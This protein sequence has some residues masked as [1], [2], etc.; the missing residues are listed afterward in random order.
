MSEAISRADLAARAPLAAGLCR[1][2]GRRV[3]LAALALC[4]I[5]AAATAQDSR[6][7]RAG[8]AGDEINLGGHAWWGTTDCTPTEFGEVYLDKAPGHGTVCVR[9]ADVKITLSFSGAPKCLGRTIRGVRVNYLAESGYVGPDDL[10]YTVKFT[11][12][13][14]TVAATVNVRPS[15]KPALPK[16]PAQPKTVQP[17]GLVPPCSA[18]VS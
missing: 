15:T 6:V 3:G 18:L 9:I 16:D 4:L 12:L 1:G 8:R 11:A 2:L 7:R 5:G 13:S 10:S 17:L 14:R